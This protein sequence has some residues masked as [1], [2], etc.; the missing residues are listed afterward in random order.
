MNEPARARKNDPRLQA[1]LEDYFDRVDRNEPVDQETF[2]SRHGEIAAELRQFIATEDELR[3]LAAESRGDISQEST[4]S[5]SQH[6]NE[7]LPPRPLDA[8]GGT[9]P[10]ELA[11]TFG[12]YRIL[13]SLGKGAMGTVY[14]AEDTQLRRQ[15]ALKT[16]QFAGDDQR[17]LLERFYREA[18]SA[19]TLRH[20][21]I[22]PV[23][24]VGDI[25]GKHYITMAYIEG[26]PLSYFVKPA[27]PQTASRIL[28]VVGKIAQA[29]Q[30]AHDHGIVHRDLKPANVMI[31]RRGEPVIM[32]FG[33]A[34]QAQQPDDLHLT[35]TGVI[36]GSPAYMSPEQVEAD[37]E[38]IGPAA[39][40]Y[41]LGVILYELLTGRVPFRGSLAS[42]MG[43]IVSQP[44]T[45][46]R[47]LCPGLDPRID[48]V[49]LRML[50]KN[51]DD[52]FPSLSAV[53]QE[54]AAI[55]RNSPARSA[56]MPPAK[57]RRL[58]WLM[59][60]AAPLAALAAAIVIL[61]LGKTTIEIDVNDP[62]VQVALRGPTVTITVPGPARESFSVE[63]GENELTIT[64]GDL[65][66]K[67][68]SPFR[69]ERGDKEVVR[70]KL[71]G[72]T[73]AATLGDKELPVVPLASG[74]KPDQPPVAKQPA[75]QEVK[76]DAPPTAVAV[77]SP[78]HT[79]RHRGVPVPGPFHLFLLASPFNAPIVKRA[80]EV[81]SRRLDV[82]VE[83]TNS[84][85]MKLKLVPP[86]QF[87][88][89]PY[90]GHFVRITHPYYVGVY[91]VTRG[92]F[93]QFVAATDF[94]TL[95]EEGNGAVVLDN[96]PQPTKWLPGHQ[97][98]WR[99]PGF[100]QED[101]HPVVQIAW[102]DAVSFCEWLSKKE[103]ARYRLPT[104]AE[105]EYACRAGTRERYYNGSD[106]EELVQIAN[107]ADASAMKVF[108]HWKESVKSSD[109]YVYTSPVGRFR[110]N[111]FGLFDMLG[112]A[113]QWCSDRYE[114]DYFKHSPTDDPRGPEKGEAHVGRGGGFT[115]VAGSRYRYNGVETLRR[116]D[117][118][119]RVVCDV[120]GADQVPVPTEAR[121]LHSAVQIHEATRDGR[122]PPALPEQA[123]AKPNDATD[124]NKSAVK[125]DAN[126]SVA[127][128]DSKISPAGQR[129]EVRAP[130]AAGEPA[131]ETNDL[132]PLTFPFG[133]PLA[134]KAQF[135]WGRR[136]K[137][138]VETSDSIRMKLVLIPP[139]EYG[140]G[141]FAGHPVRITRPCYLGVDEVTR[142]QFAQFVRA[143]GYHTVAEKMTGAIKLD[144]G[145]TGTKF[146][147][148]GEATWHDPGFAQEDDHPVVE[149]TWSDAG[150]FCLW[151]SRKEGQTYRLPTEAE[152]EYVCRAG[153]MTMFYNGNETQEVTKI[154]NVA[155][156][157]S[158]KV[159]SH[160]T[161]AVKSSDGYVY[162]SPVGRF[163]PNNFGLYDTIGNVFE[164]CS[165]W[166]GDDYYEHSPVDDPR[167]PASG[168]AH[169]WR[170]GSFTRTI[171]SRA[172]FY[173]KA[174]Y[175]RPD[176]GFRVVRE[177]DAPA[178]DAAVASP[179]VKPS[180]AS[181]KGP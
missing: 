9:K 39:D 95:A 110:P 37:P 139:G 120:E 46:P 78:P 157:T 137:L 125:T 34:R 24:D 154:G 10:G 73:V 89:G 178:N 175:R 101:D 86:G 15:I 143:T 107:V 108:P 13:R 159:F 126:K 146:F 179:T 130:A 64:H 48:A 84:I 117:W 38:K 144:D 176:L 58:W 79:R 135:A 81:W 113:C 83:R 55:V 20:P 128:T 12:R 99:D 123:N 29:L 152:W 70:I 18:R 155:D 54:L 124:S 72:S 44:P 168:D 160:W 85:G 163:Q 60:A 90:E 52:R 59:A 66:F 3:K 136:L 19:A 21:C 74:A 40:Q 50:A 153:T 180:N 57:K 91:S 118:G 172:R 100:K 177:I 169:I 47:E 131:A 112:N 94:R 14:L 6:A 115:Q 104:E 63:P 28:I 23:Y 171:G 65:K 151:L 142:G 93:A 140:M 149:V 4:G 141:N 8:A 181:S 82:P 145:K 1:A 103:N 53:S 76:P 119:F 158:S 150:A 105:W 114:E 167:G 147:A 41:S 45:P 80:E 22:C 102:S 165:D 92:Q 69:L 122:T 5:F 16:P 132:T 134:Q 7:T 173:G 138:P 33:L 25:D 49:C 106:A 31:D 97:S 162:T 166:H 111:N 88:M 116:P 68:A 148:S 121:P 26:R 71:S 170:G 43:Q 67:T 56:Q 17:E 127:N 129:P 109:G 51:P 87:L 156:A 164:W 62:D 36:M 35:Q 75:K 30:E 174:N 32:D 77:A 98:T 27:V 133:A 11:G 96:G 42:V 61:Q 2:I 161:T